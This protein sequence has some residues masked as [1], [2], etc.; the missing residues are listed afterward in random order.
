[1]TQTQHVLRDGDRQVSFYGELLSS[2]SSEEDGKDRWSEMYIYLKSD[3]SGY[4]VHGAGMS[5]RE[6]ETSREWVR[7]C[8]TADAVIKTLTRTADDIS[9]MPK[10]NVVLLQRAAMID[11]A[12]HDAASTQ[13]I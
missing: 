3:G 1:M 2:S 11:D 9:Y 7:D 4:V 8:H 10:L 5:S 6:G 12:L 13:A